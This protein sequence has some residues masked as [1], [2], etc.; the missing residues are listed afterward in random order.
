MMLCNAC[1]DL[2]VVSG[3]DEDQSS[4]LGISSWLL[5]AAIYTPSRR[6]G[7]RS[8]ASADRG[9]FEM[10]ERRTASQLMADTVGDGTSLDTT[11]YASGEHPGLWHGMI[12][13]NA[14]LG[15]P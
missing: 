5:A 6:A 8:N 11:R 1:H 12:R 14:R 3:R 2:I 10:G 15:L 13:P 9:N 4:R 7:T